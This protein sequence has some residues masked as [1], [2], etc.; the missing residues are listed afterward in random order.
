MF[1]ILE[2]NTNNLFDES[3]DFDYED[4]ILLLFTGYYTQNILI[5]NYEFKEELI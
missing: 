3:N 5:N 4:Y 2:M 1:K